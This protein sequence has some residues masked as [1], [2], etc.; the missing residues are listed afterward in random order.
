MRNFFYSVGQLEEK[1]LKDGTY[2]S[3]GVR[4]TYSNETKSAVSGIIEYL[5]GASFTRSK[6]SAFIARNYSLS[7]NE[8]VD[9]WNVDHEPKTSSNTMRGTISVASRSLYAIFG[10]GVFE[11]LLNDDSAR[12][13]SVLAGLGSGSSSFGS[14]FSDTAVLYVSHCKSDGAKEYTAE[15][16]ETEVYVLSGFLRSESDR[17]LAVAD[18]GKLA[19]IKRVLDRPVLSDGKLNSVKVAL[20]QSFGLYKNDKSQSHGQKNIEGYLG[21]GDVALLA[22]NFNRGREGVEGSVSDDENVEAIL[23]F[24]H[25]F[26]T[27][28]GFMRWLSSWDKADVAEAVYRLGLE[29]FG[30][31]DDRPE[32]CR[33]MVIK[34]G[35]CVPITK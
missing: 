19:Y 2:I 14:L 30:R 10:N 22:N 1:V 21:I 4:K 3:E 5:R 27:T 33:K 31:A 29:A 17:E 9:L 20:L 11:E 26:F 35:R 28:S 7:T 15:E 34:D 25:S 18:R 16:L 6:Q 12:I 23:G 8:L 24:F 32:D 13:L